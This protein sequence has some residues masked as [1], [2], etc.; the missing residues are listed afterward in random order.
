MNPRLEWLCSEDNPDVPQRDAYRALVIRQATGQP[1]PV[2]QPVTTIP[3]HDS[4]RAT[5]LGFQRCWFSTKDSA[6][7]CSG[8]RCHLLQRIVYLGDCVRCLTH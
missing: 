5:R 7:G 6:C 3:V 8:V 1:E 2:P 4:I